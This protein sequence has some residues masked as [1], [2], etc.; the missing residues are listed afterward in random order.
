MSIQEE[1]ASILRKY[2]ISHV[3]GY[4]DEDGNL[5]V[6]ARRARYEYSYD[7]LKRERARL[8]YLRNRE[9]IRQRQ[10]E[11]YLR[12]RSE[13]KKKKE[14]I[15]SQPDNIMMTEAEGEIHES[16]IEAV[17]GDTSILNVEFNENTDVLQEPE[18]IVVSYNRN[19]DSFFHFS[20]G[21]QKS[22]KYPELID[23][24]QLA[25]AIVYAYRQ[26]GIRVNEPD[27]METALQAMQYFGYEREILANNLEHEDLV[28]LYQLEDLGLVTSRIE[29]ITINERKP[30]RINKFILNKEKIIEFSVRQAEAERSVENLYESLPEEVW[31]R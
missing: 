10:H 15:K 6:G 9:R 28:I 12:R 18:K 5:R 3:W 11:Y 23:H 16:R 8:Y 30:W 25:S 26:Q 13:L 21:H 31:V 19:K 4:I 17:H 20:T 7:D 24:R 22:A 2:Q 29:D 1:V 14:S 27:V